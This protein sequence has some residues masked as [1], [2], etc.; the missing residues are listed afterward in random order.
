MKKDWLF[1][2]GHGDVMVKA[3]VHQAQGGEV[4]SQLGQ[5]HFYV[6]FRVE[7]KDYEVVIILR[8]LTSSC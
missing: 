1:S 3:A 6:G 8:N 7:E 2:N 5:E 4:H